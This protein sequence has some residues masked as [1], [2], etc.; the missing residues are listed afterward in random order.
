ML[1]SANVL[2]AQR[3]TP[4]SRSTAI[5][6]LLIPNP[7]PNPEYRIPNPVESHPAAKSTVPLPPPT[8]SVSP[9]AKGSSYQGSKAMVRQPM[10]HGAEVQGL[11]C[12]KIP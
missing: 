1:C 5:D 9:A 8:R 10:A 4:S 3:P 2:L 6:H 7:N 11:R 12:A